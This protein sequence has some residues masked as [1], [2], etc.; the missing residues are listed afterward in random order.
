MVSQEPSNG[1]SGASGA[2]L[3]EEPA[4]KP[5]L[6]TKELLVAMEFCKFLSNNANTDWIDDYP[7]KED[8][9]PVLHVSRN[10]HSCSILGHP[11]MLKLEDYKIVHHDDDSIFKWKDFTNNEKE[12]TD[13]YPMLVK[14]GKTYK[15]IELERYLMEHVGITGLSDEKLER[16][17]INDHRNCMHEDEADKEG[18]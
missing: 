18:R 8:K 3:N 4:V 6:S 10:C 9:R 5:K 7:D 17:M 1:A 16:M 15:G 12:A 2:S 13:A 14:D 11:F